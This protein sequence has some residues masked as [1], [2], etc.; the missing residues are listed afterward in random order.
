MDIKEAEK[1]A[2]IVKDYKNKSNK[3]LVK[4][5]EFL[6][7]EFSQTKDKLIMLSNYLDKIENTY[8]TILKEHN[9]RNGG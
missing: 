1:I 3:D 2:E 4:T 7:N 8:N 5:L 6:N 9:S